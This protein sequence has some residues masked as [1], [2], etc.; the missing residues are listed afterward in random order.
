MKPK[1]YIIGNVH[2]KYEMLSLFLKVRR[3]KRGKK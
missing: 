3:A 1:H 2:G